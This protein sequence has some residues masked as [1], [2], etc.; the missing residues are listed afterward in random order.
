MYHNPEITTTNFEWRWVLVGNIVDGHEVGEEKILRHGTKHFSPGTKVI[1]APAQWGDGYENIVVIGKQRKSFH[2]IELVMSSLLVENFRLQKVY[3]PEILKIMAAE[4]KG[5]YWGNTDKDRDDILSMVSWLNPY[6]KI[7]P[8]DIIEDIDKLQDEF[9][10]IE[11]SRRTISIKE[12][13]PKADYLLEEFTEA[14]ISE[15]ENKIESIRYEWINNN[16]ELINKCAHY[17]GNYVSQKY[18]GNW[19][20]IRNKPAVRINEFYCI[21]PLELVACYYYWRKKSIVKALESLM[22]L[23][24]DGLI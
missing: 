24:K 2:Y 1:C 13:E 19:C 10:K 6:Y 12:I 18:G 23:R 11:I 9:F 14:C 7:D 4:R 16:S 22:V 15:I 21:F 17:I 5:G 8:T 3:K 20:I